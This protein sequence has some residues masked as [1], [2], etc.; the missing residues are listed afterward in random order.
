MTRVDLK[1]VH[2]VRAASGRE[3]HYAWRGGPRFWSSDSGFP[4]G[5]AEYLAALAASAPKARS[6]QGLFRSLIIA[7]LESG[8]FAALAPRSQKDFRTSLYHPKNG[9]DA[10]FG[11]APIAAFD[12]PRIRRQVIDWRDGIGG[13]VGHDR[14]RH[15]QR[16]VAWALDRGDLRHHH[17]RE[18]TTTYRAD[19]ADVIWTPEEIAAFVAGAPPHVARILIAATETGLRPGDLAVLSR[20][21]IHPTPKGQRIVIWT[22]KRR[23]MA[24]IPVTPAMGAL[25]SAT[26]PGQSRLLVTA[27]G[28]PWQH[29]NYLGAA[30]STWRDN[31]KLR[32]DLRLYDAR[33]TAATRLLAAGAD[34]REIATHMGWSLKHAASV[35]DTYAALA[36][37]ST[38]GVAAK[39]AKVARKA[40]RSVKSSVK[41]PG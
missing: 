3:Y 17:L 4:A 41:K 28:T 21:H 30:V 1:G 25:I 15:L 20:E 31:L 23:R 5:S 40:N 9:I 8:A 33:G 13:K 36:P 22:R 29:E 12:D 32:A 27:E 34:L 16:I 14:L 37:E 38:D 35:I 18:I 39:L 6:A 26:P 7:W 2:R 19:R 10:K 11:A 24:S